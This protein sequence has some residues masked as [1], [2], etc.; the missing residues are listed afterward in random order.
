MELN[1]QFPP[2]NYLLTLAEL[3]NDLAFQMHKVARKQQH[4]IFIKHMVNIEN[5]MLYK[6]YHFA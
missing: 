5:Y 3:S 1:A 2:S 4:L 6:S